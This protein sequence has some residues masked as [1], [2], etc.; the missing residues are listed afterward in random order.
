MPEAFLLARGIT[1]AQADAI[2]T[3]GAAL[4]LS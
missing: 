4:T 2:W 1:D 3:Q